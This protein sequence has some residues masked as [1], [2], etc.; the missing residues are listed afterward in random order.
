MLDFGCG[1]GKVLR[2]FAPEAT[3][4]DF[5]GCDIDAPSIDWLQRNLCPPFNAFR[6]SEAP[7]LPQPDGYFN[8]IYAISVY[9]HLTGHW[10][11]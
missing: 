11:D 5:T 1:A 4:A 9:T 10:A 6:C 7:P 8:L 2:Q 3:V